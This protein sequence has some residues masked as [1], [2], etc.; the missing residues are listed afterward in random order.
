ML[1]RIQLFALKTSW[2]FLKTSG[3]RHC[4]RSLYELKEI[5]QFSFLLSS[6]YSSH[7]KTERKQRRR[8]KGG[9]ET[10]MKINSIPFIWY[11][12]FNF[13]QLLVFSY[14]EEKSENNIIQSQAFHRS[15]SQN[16]STIIA[17]LSLNE[18]FLCFPASRFTVEATT[19]RKVKTNEIINEK[20]QIM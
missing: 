10:K 15:L 20:L 17:F 4:Y 14:P 3:S 18:L 9:E 7:K 6:F 16:I 5:L 13:F 11:R 12:S 1:E 8:R 2:Y 19:T